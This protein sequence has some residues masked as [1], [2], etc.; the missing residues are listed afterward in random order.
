MSAGSAP[1]SAENPSAPSSAGPS[2]SLGGHLRATAILLVLSI[3]VSG[4]AYPI[5]V[6]E[7]AHVL[8]PYAAGG[9]LVRYPNGVVAGSEYVAQNLTNHSQP[10]LFWARPSLTDYNTTLGADT[11]PGP[12]D[13]ALLA[14]F[15]ETLSYMRL[16]GNFTVNATLPIWLVAPSGSSIDPD[17]VPEAVLVQVP[18]I[19]NNTNLSELGYTTLNERIQFLTGF[20]NEHITQPPL[21]FVGVPYINVLKLDLALL[22]LIGR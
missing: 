6:T 11:P 9:S 7:V 17:L 13:P 16:Y 3:L 19:A 22:P 12:S 18:R 4:F 10:W 1:R 5:V 20:V 14:L 8:D 2:H 15:N 21:P